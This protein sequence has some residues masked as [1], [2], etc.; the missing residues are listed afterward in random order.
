MARIDAGEPVMRYADDYWSTEI[1]DARDR[2]YGIALRRTAEVFVLARRPMVRFL[3]IGTGPGLFLDAV[4][5]YL[6]LISARCHGVELFPPPVSM[7]TKQLQYHVG[8]VADY[9]PDSFDGGICIE[10]FEHLTPLMLDGLL[11]GLAR[12]SRDGACYVINTGLADYALAEDPGYLDPVGRG[13]ITS[14]TV[15]AINHLAQR[16]GLQAQAIPGRAWSFVLEKTTAEQMPIA[17]RLRTPL[18]E[19]A[20]VLRSSKLIDIAEPEI[21]AAL[22]SQ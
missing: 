21:V 16:H 8:Q 15:Q 2:A 19:N 9:E 17:E 5:E 4:A 10:V 20:A 12:V 7:R 6:P 22:R 3:D 18:P 14:W 1:A 11:R 13:H